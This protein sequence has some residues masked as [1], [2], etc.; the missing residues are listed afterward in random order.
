MK[1]QIIFS[2]SDDNINMFKSGF[3]KKVSYM[4]TKDCNI[5][6]YFT[7]CLLAAM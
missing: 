2:H 3:V 4:F 6:I 7:E 1:D 5:D